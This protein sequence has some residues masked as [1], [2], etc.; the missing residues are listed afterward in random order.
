MLV[1][2]MLGIHNSRSIGWQFHTQHNFSKSMRYSSQLTMQDFIKL[3]IVRN[4][5]SFVRAHVSSEATSLF[6]PNNRTLSHTSDSCFASLIGMLN[7]ECFYRTL[8]KRTSHRSCTHE[9]EDV[10]EAVHIWLTIPNKAGRTSPSRP[11]K[12]GGNF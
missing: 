10:E 9:L 11:W 12:N 8:H 5:I 2:H 4:F 3:L 6:K 7:N 1:D